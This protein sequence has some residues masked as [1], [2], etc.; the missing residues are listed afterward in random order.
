MVLTRGGENLS[1]GDR[2]MVGSTELLFF[3][4]DPLRFPTMPLKMPKG[5]QQLV[6]FHPL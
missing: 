3:D 6:D 5:L 1:S 2:I 4:G